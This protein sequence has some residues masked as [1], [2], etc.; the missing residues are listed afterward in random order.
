MDSKTISV[1][2][3]DANQRSAL[4]V[5]R[6]LGRQP[7]LRIITCDSTPTALAGQ[8]RF[9][10]LYVQ[11][12]SSEHE[13]MHFVAWLTRYL[14]TEPC[15]VVMPVTEVTSQLLLQFQESVP[16][17][18]LPFSPLS[19]V[20]EL[21][22]KSRLV[23]LAERSGVPVPHSLHFDGSAEVDVQAVTY[24]VVVKPALSRL[25]DGRQWQATTVRIA[26][27][28][29]ELAGIFQQDTY[30]ND[31]PFML[32]AFIPGTG[33][34]VFALF[35]RG[36][37]VQF[38]AHQRL[39]EK[40]PEGGVSVLSQ[41]CS[42]P[43]D[44]QAHAQ[45]LLEAVNWHGVAMVEFRISEDG[46]PYLM[47]VNTRFWGSLQLAI[48]AGVDF[49]YQLLCAELGWPI[50]LAGHYRVGQRLRWLLGDLDS[51]YLVFKRSKDW[52]TRLQRAGQFLKPRFRH[53]RHEINR[54]HDPAPAWHEL[55]HYLKALR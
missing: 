29:D 49:P 17:L 5:V 22:N 53:Q 45:T 26:H 46:T 55:K 47:E 41:S 30:L 24:P 11:C 31:H 21:A 32:Q 43:A 25:F 35:N 51:L 2:V 10:D 37:A 23:A 6:S 18:T 52:R 40:P 39:R 13:P 34:G 27:N 3:P 38:F 9:S 1:L 7:G 42:V 4:A 28:P 33:A 15:R 48:D 8:S 20:L 44:L 12:P 54:W 36:K 16:G 19:T 50:P 14:E